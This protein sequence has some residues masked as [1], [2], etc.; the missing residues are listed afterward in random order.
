MVNGR[1]LGHHGPTKG[2]KVSSE[3][4][5]RP[6]SYLENERLAYENKGQEKPEGE[7]H[8]CLSEVRCGVWVKQIQF[9]MVQ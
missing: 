6:Q 3:S 7:N 1:I 4:L 8:G 5:K 9:K 2:L